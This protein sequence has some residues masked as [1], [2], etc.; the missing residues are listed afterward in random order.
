MTKF[1][2]NLSNKFADRYPKSYRV[3][4]QVFREFWFPFV[5]A[6]YWAF[7]RVPLSQSDF[8]AA[9]VAQLAT[10]FIL[11]SW[12]IGQLVRISR[13]HKVEDSFQGLGQKMGSMLE[14]AERLIAVTEG[15][16]KQLAE[17]LYAATQTAN[18][19]VVAANNAILEARSFG[20]AWGGTD[21]QLPPRLPIN[22]DI[23]NSAGG[24]ANR[25][26]D[27]EKK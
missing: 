24:T 3:A 7:Y 27:L 21:W 20:G 10:S 6:L 22:P 8:I 16:P 23:Y 17:Q 18:T 19:Q 11:V 5:I 15:M 9:F 2:N 26:M 1:L 4:K 13:Q 12:G 25:P 14:I